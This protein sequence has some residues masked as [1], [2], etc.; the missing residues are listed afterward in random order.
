MYV[1]RF[2]PSLVSKLIVKFFKI[3][4]HCTPNSKKINT[5]IETQFS[6]KNLKLKLAMIECTLLVLRH[7]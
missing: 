6:E 3:S 1:K 5:K 2:E 7:P 4:R